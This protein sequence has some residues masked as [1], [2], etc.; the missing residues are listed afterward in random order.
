MKTLTR[1]LVLIPLSALLL[2]GCTRSNTRVMFT[3]LDA[4]QTFTLAEQL[5]QQDNLNGKTILSLAATPRL[6]SVVFA[7]VKDNGLVVSRDR[8]TTWQSTGLTTG[9]P[10]DVL[11]HPQAVKTLFVASGQTILRS[12]DDAA[13][14]STIYAE[15]GVGMA[16]AIDPAAPQNVWAGSDQGSLV[17]SNDAGKTWHVAKQFSRPVTDIMISPLGSAVIVGTAGTGLFVSADR[18]KTFEERS[19]TVS[20]RKTINQSAS[21]IIA[22]AQSAAVGSP[23]VAATTDGLF[24]TNNL[25]KDWTELANPIVTAGTLSGLAASGGEPA[26][27]VAVA[28]NTVAVSHDGGKTWTTRDVTTDRPLGPIAVVGLT[29]VVGVVGESQGF[30]QRNLQQ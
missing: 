25:G 19:P 23:L 24:S 18:G 9:S 4:G 29:V 3:S 17:E 15:P 11:I 5:N 12:T 8:G 27:L 28:A 26:L 21:Q 30:I 7:G 10:Q 14:F 6:P 13:T 22:I 1:S 2:A 16:I 20:E